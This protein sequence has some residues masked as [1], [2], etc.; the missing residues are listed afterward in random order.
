MVSKSLSILILL[1]LIFSI[2]AI[3]ISILK[4]EKLFNKNTP[5]VVNIIP[6]E[7]K[8]KSSHTELVCVIDVSG[9]MLG[10]KIK[11]VKQSLK[12]LLE[13]MG[14]KDKLGLVLFNHESQ[15]L[16]D[17]TYTTNGNKKKIISLIDRIK[18]SGGTY[19]LGGLEIAVNM[20]ESSQKKRII[21]LNNNLISSAIILLSDGMDNKMDH[22][23]I[24]NE[25]KNLNK[26][27]NLIYTLHAFGYGNDHDPK[28]MNTLATIGDGSFYFVEEYKKVVQYLV[29]VLGACVSMFSEKAI[30][31][32]KAKY[33]IIK[34]YGLK[35]LYK[36]LFKDIYFETELLQIIAGREYTYVFEM[37]IPEDKYDEDDYIEVEFDYKD[38]KKGNNIITK[39]RIEKMDE[40]LKEK[41]NEEYLRVVAFESMNDAANLREENKKQEAEDLLNYMKAWINHNYKGKENYMDYINESLKF[42][43]N[44]IL[45]EQKGYAAI[46]S[47]VRENMMKGGGSGMKFQ[48][49]MQKNMVSNLNNFGGFLR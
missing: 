11:L 21:N 31:R 4:G 45:Y 42:I 23:E 29:N 27:T 26:K 16:L 10:E 7:I 48:N 32:I 34:I 9:S 17:L 13:L 41:A 1:I 22:I 30:I 15:K 8:E 3:D 44:D 24:G 18:A 28:L 49:F 6:E 25:L 19:I 36:Y 47:N 33:K 14:E 39:N 43:K 35:S 40:S 46:S 12:V 2:K 20:L 5:I 38:N 37:E